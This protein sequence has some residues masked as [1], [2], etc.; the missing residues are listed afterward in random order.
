MHFLVTSKHVF[1]TAPAVKFPASRRW[2][3]AALLSSSHQLSRFDTSGWLRCL[4]FW[5]VW[6]AQGPISATGTAHA[7]AQRIIRLS[8][9][10]FAVDVAHAYLEHE[11]LDTPCIFWLSD[12]SIAKDSVTPERSDISLLPFELR[13]L[14]LKLANWL[15]YLDIL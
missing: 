4:E 5:Y 15:T 8:P 2:R 9:H 6:S 7:F 10:M 1:L 14:F 3:R 11:T 12:S 13:R